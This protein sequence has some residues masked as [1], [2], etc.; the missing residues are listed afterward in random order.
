MKFRLFGLLAGLI[1]L[2]LPA[3]AASKSD[4]CHCASHTIVRRVIAHPVPHHAAVRPAPHA[5]MARPLPHAAIARRETHHVLV[6]REERR[7]VVR[8]EARR[9]IVVRRPLPVARARARDQYASSYYDYRSSSRVTETVERREDGMSRRYWRMKDGS[10]DRDPRDT[11][12]D[13]QDHGAVGVNPRDFNGGVGYGS[14]GAAAGGY[15]YYGA[16]GGMNGRPID[17]YGYHADAAGMARVRMN[18]WHGYNSHA[19]NGY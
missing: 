9:M 11:S 15:A 1:A 6:R 19:G 18:A 4:D 5:A 12:R 10:Y 13:E 2:S 17:N 14:D 8:H 3:A 16:P 7:A